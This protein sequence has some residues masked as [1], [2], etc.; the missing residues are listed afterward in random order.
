MEEKEIMFAFYLNQENETGVVM[1]DDTISLIAICVMYC[2][3]GISVLPI[4]VAYIT[5]LH[6]VIIN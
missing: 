5:N 1:Q 4:V 6:Q 3:Q 2:S